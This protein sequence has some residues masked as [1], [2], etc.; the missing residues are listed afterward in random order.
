[1]DKA[2]RLRKLMRQLTNEQLARISDLEPEDF[3]WSSYSSRQC[4]SPR[5]LSGHIF[6]LCV[7][8]RRG[9]HSLH[10]EDMVFAEEVSVAT[11]RMIP[12]DIIEIIQ[13]EIHRRAANVELPEPEGEVA[14]A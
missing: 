10:S 11:Q 14:H 2:T 1:M 9:F 3:E 4:G 7:E 13:E 8:K 12:D 6:D 5:C